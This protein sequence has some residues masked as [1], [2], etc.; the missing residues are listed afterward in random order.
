MSRPT[1]GLFEPVARERVISE[2]LDRSRQRFDALSDDALA[3]LL[4]D[5]LYHERKRLERTKPADG[6]SARLDLLA[7]ALVRGSRAERATAGMELVASWVEEIHGRFSRRA[8][9]I[10][11]TVLPSA[12]GGL[13]NARPARL[14]DW[15]VSLQSRVKV[16]GDVELVR[17]L[18]EEA[19]VILAPTHVSN[20]D[21]PLIGFALAEAGL[22]PF[23]YGAGLNLFS[24]PVMGW[25]MR[26][27]GAYTVD[28]TKRASLYKE[29]LKDYSVRCLTTRHHSLFFPGGTRARSGALE[30]KLKKG[31]LGTG[32]AAYQEML[33]AGRP[34]PEV[35]VVPMTLSFQLVLE[36]NTLISDHLEEQGRQ[37]YIISDDEFTQ[38][39]R[40]A[41][42]A[43]RVLELD[44]S[45]VCRFGQPL[46]VLGNP[47]A[48]DV[49][50]RVEQAKERRRYVCDRAGKVELDEQRDFIYTERLAEA[51]VNE[52]PKAATVM[53]THAVAWAAWRWLER[54]L[55]TTDP[56]RLVRTPI[57]RRAIPRHDFLE[58]LAQVLGAVKA[59]AEAGQW[60]HALP[61]TAG[62]LLDEALDRF[63]RYH[64]SR[65]LVL[66]GSSL[67]ID[68]PKLCLYYRNRLV[69]AELERTCG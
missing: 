35:Y 6:E 47:V 29:V 3:A 43:Q 26:R 37:R 15:D 8:Y 49:E 22:P 20:L 38:P 69:F 32:L 64:R 28:R 56:F 46:D 2:L 30:T 50:G 14:R 21:S 44:A 10:A 18:T 11:T 58:L 54:E 27:L 61:E 62:A 34:D 36:A 59:G 9:R 66:R 19:T 16:A 42:F 1:T 65:A 55:G 41:Q 17:T 31:L 52:F 23:V 67:V 7:D 39:R 60:C 51:L 45:I 5:A 53:P 63:A 24:N 13:L 68:D 48:S 40:L 12:L 57:G 33:A 4:E 25:W